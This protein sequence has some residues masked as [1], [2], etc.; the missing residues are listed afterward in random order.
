VL[1]AIGRMLAREPA[2]FDR[3]LFTYRSYDPVCYWSLVYAFSAL[4]P[5]SAAASAIDLHSPREAEPGG[6]AE[7]A[8]WAAAVAMVGPAVT[9]LLARRDDILEFWGMLYCPSSWDEGRYRPA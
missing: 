7:C 3:R 1:A 6:A 9:P 5:G 2:L 4:L 8:A